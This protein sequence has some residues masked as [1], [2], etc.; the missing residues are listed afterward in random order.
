MNKNMVGFI[1]VMLIA[2]FVVVVSLDLL[3]SGLEKYSTDQ[4]ETVD[5]WKDHGNGVWLYAHAGDL[6]DLASKVAKWREEHPDEEILTIT[7]FVDTR[8]VMIIT[9]QDRQEEQ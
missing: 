7:V 9:K 6:D 2:G 4:P 3:K 1:L 5:S 8:H